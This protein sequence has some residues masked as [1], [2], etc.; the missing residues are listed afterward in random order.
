MALAGAVQ[1]AQDKLLN[2]FGSQSRQDHR[3]GNARAD[4][5]IDGKSQGLKQGRL[6]DQN[7]VVGMW[8]I[9]AQQA[10]FAQ[11]LRWHEVSVVDDG[12]EHF[13]GAVD[14]ESFLDQEA[15]ATVVVALELDLKGLA[16]NA[17]GVVIGV[18]RPV[19]NDLLSGSNATP[20]CLAQ[21]LAELRRF[22]I[23]IAAPSEL[24]VQ[25]AH[26]RLGL[27]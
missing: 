6:A 19:I 25:F 17:Q 8:K 11:T 15:F 24:R 21:V 2:D 23:R 13:A 3:V 16:K 27:C 22:E 26:T 20:Q 18:K 9:L 14:F 5:L 4:F 12:N 7:Q 1:L 10:Q